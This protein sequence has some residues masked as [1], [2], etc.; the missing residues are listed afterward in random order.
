MKNAKSFILMAFSLALLASPVSSSPSGQ[1]WLDT[2]GESAGTVSS[3]LT[4][5]GRAAVPT[6]V[7]P[8]RVTAPEVAEIDSLSR[9]W[10]GKA[11]EFYARGSY[12]MALTYN[13]KAL[14]ANPTLEIAWCNKGNAL[15]ALG[16]YP[17]ALVAFDTAITI[18][19]NDPWAWA[20]KSS[21]LKA[22]GQNT[23][24]ET[25]FTKAKELGYSEEE[26][27]KTCRS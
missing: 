19:Q 15:L 22:L 25:A 12:D 17:E 11:N 16:R 4:I 18:N 27:C 1:F 20:G 26:S 14:T 2:Y 3:G 6:Y 5:P 24:A 13:D 10:M 8:Y 7:G 21:A 9:Y 23:D